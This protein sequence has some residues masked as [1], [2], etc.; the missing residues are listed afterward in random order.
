MR[1]STLPRAAP[2]G[3]DTLRFDLHRLDGT[4]EGCM[5]RVMLRTQLA[6]SGRILLQADLD[7]QGGVHNLRA[8]RHRETPGIGAPQL[9][10][11]GWMREFRGHQWPDAVSGATF[12]TEAVLDTVLR[13]QRAFV[14]LGGT[15]W[16]LERC[17]A[18]AA[19][20]EEDEGGQEGG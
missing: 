7:L 3:G 4:V 9:R 17:Q 16:M 6:Y 11:S 13:L 15:D 5:A 1:A 14:Q 2:D 19:G 8:R 12:T 18:T 10:A 20:N